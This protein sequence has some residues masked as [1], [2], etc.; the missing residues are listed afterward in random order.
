MKGGYGIVILAAGESSRLNFPK[1]LLE[2]NGTSFLKKT[3][4]VGCSFPVPVI[5]VLGFNYAR[6][7]REI[8]PLPTEVVLNINWKKGIGSSIKCGLD[9]L[10]RNHPDIERVIFMTCDQPYVDVELLQRM[11]D[12]HEAGH[13]I[14][15]ASYNNDYGMPILVD[16][17]YFKEVLKIKDS[18]DFSI[19][20]MVYGA[21]GVS[22]PLGAID[23]DTEEQW[24]EYFQKVK[25]L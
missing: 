17:M 22:F 21:F 20:T 10:H 24:V 8:N 15:A 14:V 11:I 4:Q 23:I 6:L 12:A 25:N 16:Q 7:E 5:T 18:D 1:Q 19:L 2:I 3:V 9:Y 13:N